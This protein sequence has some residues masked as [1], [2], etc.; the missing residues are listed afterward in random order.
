MLNTAIDNIPETSENEEGSTSESPPRPDAPSDSGFWTNLRIG[1]GIAAII[2]IL[3]GVAVAAGNNNR[4][5][6]VRIL[7][8]FMK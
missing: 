1:L 3:L 5:K 6:K 4:R 2:I 7:M 8:L